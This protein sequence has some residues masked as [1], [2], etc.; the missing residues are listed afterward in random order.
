MKKIEVIPGETF[1]HWTIIK[2][3][4]KNCHGHR[5]VQCRCQCG[6]IKNIVFTRV[7]TGRSTSCG[8]RIKTHKTCEFVI[9]GKKVN[10]WTVIEEVERNPTGRR[11]VRC[12]CQCGTIQV[13]AFNSLRTEKAQSC[14]CTRLL[15]AEKGDVYGGWTIIEE[16]ERN[17][18][19]QRFVRCLCRCGEVNDFLFSNLRNGRAKTCGCYRRERKILAAKKD[20]KKVEQ[21]NHEKVEERKQVPSSEWMVKI[22]DEFNHW[23]VVKHVSGSGEE[24][25]FLCECRCETKK[26]FYGKDLINRVN[27]SCI[28]QQKESG[29]ASGVKIHHWTVRQEKGWDS[30]GYQ[31]LECKCVC[32]EVKNVRATHL[33]NGTMKSCG[34]RGLV[35]KVGE[36][37]NRWTVMDEVRKNP[38]GVRCVRCRCQ[39]GTVQE[40]PLDELCTG[41]SQSCG[42]YRSD[43]KVGDQ[44]YR[45]TVV[46]HLSGSQTEGLF[47]CQCLCGTKKKFDASDI[48][49]KASMS[50]GCRKRRNSQG[51]IVYIREMD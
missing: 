51:E 44:F 18:H 35:A 19:G 37:F 5:V 43:V 38:K 15:K 2:E 29:L 28:C 17:R 7:R 1:N 27:L 20:E 47:W 45:W 16:I 31:L 40:V 25:L 3:I 42:C 26:R 13:L 30:R 46:E 23:T 49:D 8:C 21:Q 12:R 41:K 9:P 11:R 22:A 36:Q 33:R 24:A 4:E 10:H 14:G 32:G 6:E 34:C 39:C 48:I 50:C